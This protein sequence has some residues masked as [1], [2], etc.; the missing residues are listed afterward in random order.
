MRPLNIDKFLHNLT[1]R[2]LVQNF[3]MATSTSAQ[4]G[5][6]A[7]KPLYKMR[8]KTDFYLETHPTYISLQVQVMTY[9]KLLKLCLASAIPTKYHLSLL[10]QMT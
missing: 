8:K 1:K 3:I 4:V 6:Q 7:Y 2:I 10:S 5:A 9:T